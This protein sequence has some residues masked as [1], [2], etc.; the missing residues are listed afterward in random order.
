MFLLNAISK[1]FKPILDNIGSFS[2]RKN[3][4]SVC[5]CICF[6]GG[7]EE[8]ALRLWRPFVKVLSLICF[9]VVLKFKYSEKATKIEK[10]FNLVLT[11]QS[12]YKVKSKLKPGLSMKAFSSKNF[13][14]QTS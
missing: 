7:V 14:N 2:L 12:N 5:M 10:T 11:L 9:Q 3:R 8:K 4:P 6:D 13:Y 1:K